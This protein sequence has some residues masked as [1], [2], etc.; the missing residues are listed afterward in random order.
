M[1]LL[2]V[3]KLGIFCLFRIMISILLELV[4]IILFIITA[5]IWWL[6]CIQNFLASFDDFIEKVIHY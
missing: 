6:K 3:Y 5:P 1:E 4:F 2:E